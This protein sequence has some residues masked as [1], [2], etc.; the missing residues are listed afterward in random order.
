LG[1]PTRATIECAGISSFSC[2][3]VHFLVLFT[4]KSTVR[5]E[6]RL[7]GLFII[8]LPERVNWARHEKIDG[9]TRQES[10]LSNTPFQHAPGA[11]DLNPPYTKRPEN[12]PR[13]PGHDVFIQIK[14]APN[15]SDL[16][17]VSNGIDVS[18]RFSAE[19]KDITT[20]RRNY[21]LLSPWNTS[22]FYQIH[23]MIGIPFFL[24]LPAYPTASYE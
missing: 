3:T 22:L 18:V 14:V 15:T 11:D 16:L 23:W 8:R 19:E 13:Q 7:S 10:G 5:H 20:S 21:P 1:R 2:L 24:L 4:R 9:D 17:P 6:S 12:A